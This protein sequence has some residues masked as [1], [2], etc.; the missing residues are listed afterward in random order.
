MFIYYIMIIIKDT[1]ILEGIAGGL[2]IIIFVTLFNML[3][4]NSNDILLKS[5]N[6]ILIWAFRKLCVNIYKYK[7]KTTGKQ[8]PDIIIK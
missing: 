2:G 4:Q 8:L 5:F 1:E 6:W 7:F 3:F